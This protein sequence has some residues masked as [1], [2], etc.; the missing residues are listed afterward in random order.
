MR[1]KG[2]LSPAVILLLSL[3]VAPQ[4]VSGQ[5][6]QAIPAGPTT[7]DQSPA[8]NRPGAANKDKSPAEGIGGFA[9]VI[10]I[11]TEIAEKRVQIRESVI[12]KSL[13]DTFLK[14]QESVNK[15]YVDVK[16]I[17]C[18]SEQDVKT[19]GNDIEAID[20]S[21][22]SWWAMS[23]Q[24]QRIE[25]RVLNQFLPSTWWQAKPEEKCAILKEETTQ[26]N[27]Q[28]SFKE[29]ALASRK[30]GEN[31]DTLTKELSNL[32]ERRDSLS[33]SQTAIK[34]VTQNLPWIL[35]II[36]VFAF[37]VMGIVYFFESDIQMEWVASGQVTQFAT[38]MI[39][40]STLMA[41]GLTD[42]LHEQVLGTLL[43]GIAGYVLAQGVGRATARATLNAAAA[44]GPAPPPPSAAAPPGPPPPPP[45]AAAP[46]GPPPPPP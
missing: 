44:A 28:D 13:T 20:K 12:S 40:L 18:K 21:V 4:P 2:S 7:P 33:S 42:V 24:M 27:V 14:T 3:L 16:A 41:L 37:A 32:Y 29:A 15:G 46:P 8:P 39:L 10:D 23:G 17:D 11:E 9:K 45:S 1:R 30:Y 25:G 38:V 31:I 19:L 5:G 22:S 26:R 6:E 43:G 35:A 36:A 34:N